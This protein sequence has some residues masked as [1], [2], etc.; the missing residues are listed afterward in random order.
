M[1]Q[2]TCPNC[3]LT[4]NLENRKEIDF[5]LIKNAAKKQPKTFTELLHITRLSRKT[6]SLRLKELC[7]DGMLIK[8]KGLY[9]LNGAAKFKDSNRLLG[10]AFPS[11]FTERRMRTASMLIAFLLCSSVSGYVLAMILMPSQENPE[12]MIIG[13]FPATLE[14]TDVKNLYAWQVIIIFD[15]SELAVMETTPGGFL[16]EEFPFFVSATDIGEGIL[17]LGGTLVKGDVPKSG[18]GR[19]ANIVF[20]YYTGEYIEPEI[21]L[22]Q[23]RFETYLIDSKGSLIDADLKLTIIGDK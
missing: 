21:V 20:G 2:I 6:L 7:S 3:G 9:R 19:L 18:S 23:E 16:G 11:I 12:P 1:P 8:S 5:D 4:I 17:L 22:D 10:K 15:S 14:V 13:D